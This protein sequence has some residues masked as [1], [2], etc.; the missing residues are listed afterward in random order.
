MCCIKCDAKGCYSNVAELGSSAK[1][2]CVCVWNIKTCLTHSSRCLKINSNTELQRTRLNKKKHRNTQTHTFQQIVNAVH[3]R[4][5]H[6]LSWK[7]PSPFK[8]L[9]A[10]CKHSISSFLRTTQSS[11][12]MQDASA[13]QNTP[14]PHQALSACFSCPS[15]NSR[16]IRLHAVEVACGADH[17]AALLGIELVCA[18]GER[19]SL[20]PCGLGG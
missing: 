3:C 11:Y 7:S 2:A 16:S 8:I 13:Y 12:M 5:Q 17:V 19:L 20:Q 15:R 1:D 9:S 18:R 10:S 4:T 14:K 6:V